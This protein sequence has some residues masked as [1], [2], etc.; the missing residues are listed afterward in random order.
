MLI[1]KQYELDKAAK[2]LKEGKV[3]AFPTETV[4][5]L[6][7]VYDDQKAYDELCAVKRRPP[8]KP[9]TLM[10]SDVKDVEKYADLNRVAEALVKNFMPGQFTII[11]KAKP[12]LP[13][14][15]VS[16]TGNV[17]IRIADYDLIRDL[18]RKTGK[19]LLVPSANRS[20][21]KPATTT[22]EVIDAFGE[23]IPAIVEGQSISNIPSTIVFVTEKYTDIFREGAVKIDD[24][25]RVVMEVNK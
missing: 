1:L 17:G 22:Q 24:I 25:K 16:E 8:E 5:G 13:A 9:F 14:W 12:G 20:G 3:I 4:Y 19:P 23:E 7:V 11:T 21:E 18:I 15:C 10:L 6:G 2:L